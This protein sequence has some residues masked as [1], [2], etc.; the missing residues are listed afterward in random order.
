M[1][2]DARSLGAISLSNTLTGRA[3]RT[4][5]PLPIAQCAKCLREVV[6]G[7][8]RVCALT[9]A[10]QKIFECENIFVLGEFFERGGN[11]RDVAKAGLK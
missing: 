11:F 10:G 8:V 4:L 5:T 9:W 3:V 6:R 2:S 7:G 1:S